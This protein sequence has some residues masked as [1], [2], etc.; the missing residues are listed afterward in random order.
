MKAGGSMNLKAFSKKYVFV[1]LL[2]CV[3]ELFMNLIGEYN[4]TFLAKSITNGKY[5]IDMLWTLVLYSVVVFTAAFIIFLMYFKEQSL[6]YSLKKKLLCFAGV[7]VGYE[8]IKA[9]TYAVA[10]DKTQSLYFVLGNIYLFAVQIVIYRLFNDTEEILDKKKLGINKKMVIASVI[11]VVTAAFSV[12]YEF[13]VKKN[14]N[15]LYIS[16][17][18][19]VLG[20]ILALFTAVI[21]SVFFAA[22]MNEEVHESIA[23]KRQLILFFGTLFLALLLWV[24]KLAKP[25]G[26]LML[27]SHDSHFDLGQ[28]P[29]ES[30]FKLDYTEIQYNRFVNRELTPVYCKKISTVYC[31]EK[32]ICTYERIPS[33]DKPGSTGVGS[34]S[35][36]TGNKYYGIYEDNSLIV[37]KAENGDFEYYLRSGEKSE[38]FDKTVSDII[39]C[40]Q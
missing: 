21:Q 26:A 32:K 3:Q 18:L 16:G 4:K 2:F 8:V 7:T 17:K 13:S 10:K 40:K 20:F 11:T 37:Y 38:G 22:L 23:L 19:F 29:G 30:D 9:I 28:N 36:V 25:E 33:T 31:G 39:K 15:S 34:V 35:S 12:V 6:L 5:I 1:F 27:S 24:F 14:D